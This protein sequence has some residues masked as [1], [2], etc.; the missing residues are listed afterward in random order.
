MIQ[1]HSYVNWNNKHVKEWYSILLL[2]ELLSLLICVN[3]EEEEEEKK[4]WW[5]VECATARNRNRF[6]FNLWHSLALLVMLL[7][8][9]NIFLGKYAVVMLINV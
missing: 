1:I 2:K 3:K 5:N 9:L 4:H 8:I 7:S 6:W